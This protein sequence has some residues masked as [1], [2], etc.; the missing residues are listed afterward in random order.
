MDRDINMN[1]N[2]GFGGEPGRSGLG[3]SEQAGGEAEG[4]RE[5]TSE[6]VERGKDRAHEAVEQGRD[7]LAAGAERIGD[8][9]HD[10]ANELEQRGGVGGR[11]GT[12]LHRA[13]DSIEDAA[14]Y[15]RSHDLSEVRDDLERQIRTH[16]L[17]SVGIALG[18]GYILGRILD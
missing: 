13:G 14:E 4:L 10:R 15:V 11:V 9:L 7:K 18:A 12:G 8:R 16:P 3:E 17:I 2:P 5:R 1:P 6:A